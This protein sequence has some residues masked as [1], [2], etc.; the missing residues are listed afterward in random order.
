MSTALD[1]DKYSKNVCFSVKTLELLI[2][3]GLNLQTNISEL[4]VYVCVIS[5]QGSINRRTLDF[6]RYF[7]T[8]QCETS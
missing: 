6:V 1:K 2:N 5:E 3:V 7:L 8:Q 4:S